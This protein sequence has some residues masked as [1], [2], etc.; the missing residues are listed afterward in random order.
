MAKRKEPSDEKKIS[1]APLSFE[2]ALEG[3]LQVAPPPK[4]EPP[5]RK[6]PK[7]PPRRKRQPKPDAK[8]GGQ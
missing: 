1:L 3:L 7:E 8:Q 2:E 5:E 6:P 4:D